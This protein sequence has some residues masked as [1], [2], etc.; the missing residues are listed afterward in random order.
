MIDAEA[1]AGIARA[2]RG[3]ARERPARC[4]SRRVPA[5]CARGTFVPPTLIEIGSIAELE[6]EVFG[7]VLHVLRYPARR[8]A[9]R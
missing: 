4:T 6:R 7:P 1:Q 2:H 9:T 3:D 8:P 5:A